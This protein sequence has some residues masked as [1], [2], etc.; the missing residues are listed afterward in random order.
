[1]DNVESIIIEH[2]RSIR[3]DISTVKDDVRELKNRLVNL[4]AGQATMMQHLGHQAGVTAQQHV[5][6]DR[7]IER[8]EKIERRLELQ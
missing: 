6:Y 5:S 1:M 3:A 8:I 2:L 7:I 4:E